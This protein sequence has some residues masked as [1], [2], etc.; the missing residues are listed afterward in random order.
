MKRV[1]L[2]FCAML[3]CMAFAQDFSY[4]HVREASPE[5]KTLTV[6]DATFGRGVRPVSTVYAWED[7]ANLRYTDREGVHL[8]PLEGGEAALLDKTAAS[9]RKVLPDGA[10]SPVMSGERTARAWP[11]TARMRAA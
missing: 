9:R 1:C 6:E 11:S 3:P 7:D 10:S 4:L 2:L 5:G 8:V